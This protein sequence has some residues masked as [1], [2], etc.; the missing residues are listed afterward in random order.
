MG[1]GARGGVARPVREPAAGSGPRDLGR[2]GGMWGDSS[3][4]PCP[5]QGAQV[6]VGVGCPGAEPAQDVPLPA[7]DLRVGG[8]SSLPLLRSCPHD[9]CAQVGGQGKEDCR[10][11]AGKSDCGPLGA[12]AWALLG[13]AWG[14][15]AG[16]WA[17]SPGTGSHRLGGAG[18]GCGVGAKFSRPTC[19]RAHAGRPAWALLAPPGP[20]LSCTHGSAPTRPAGAAAATPRP[21][22]LTGRGP[23][24]LG[25][26]AARVEAAA[27][28]RTAS[29]ARS[30]GLPASQ[31]LGY[32]QC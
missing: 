21:G 11:A 17:A 13:A 32:P 30:P 6:G 28:P 31:P 24:G 27:R 10:G 25:G 2:W 19:F 23:G 8:A 15:P 5:P 3:E 4:S 12:W 29:R 1:F 9:P 18:G 7:V 22:C 26:L 16:R 14:Y 20:G